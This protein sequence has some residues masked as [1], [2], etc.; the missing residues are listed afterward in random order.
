MLQHR[1][2]HNYCCT[3]KI[4]FRNSSFVNASYQKLFRK[5]PKDFLLIACIQG[6]IFCFSLSISKNNNIHFSPTAVNFFG[7]LIFLEYMISQKYELNR[8][9]HL[10]TQ[11]RLPKSEIGYFTKECLRFS[12][13]FGFNTFPWIIRQLLTPKD[14]LRSS[15]SNQYFCVSIITNFK[16]C[17]CR[18]V[19]S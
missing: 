13:E 19:G 5:F 1:K 11:Q 6:L 4:N 16:K 8:Q 3:L 14:I 17:L 9:L 10:L 15:R 7:W 18:F 2:R 12:W